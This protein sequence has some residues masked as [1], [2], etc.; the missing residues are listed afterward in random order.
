MEPSEVLGIATDAIF[1]LLKIA[2]PVMSVALIVG[3][4]ISLFQALTQ[5]QE[6]TLSFVPKIVAIFISLIIFLPYIFETLRA[7]AEQLSARM[8]GLS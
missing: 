5:I 8:I 2:L 4:A 3:L 1:V 6:M 7:F